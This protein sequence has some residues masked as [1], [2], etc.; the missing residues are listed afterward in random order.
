M[1]FI[2][3]K[4]NDTCYGDST[5]H[6][7]SNDSAHRGRYDSSVRNNRLSSAHWGLSL[8]IRGTVE[9]GEE[10]VVVGVYRIAVRGTK[11]LP[12]LNLNPTHRKHT[13]SMAVPS[14]PTTI[15]PLRLH[16]SG[17][18]TTVTASP[19]VRLVTVNC[20]NVNI[21]KTLVDA[22][23]I[24]PVAGPEGVNVVPLTAML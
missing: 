12:I 20:G 24:V 17:V 6:G 23:L 9:V 10:P 13:Y 18:R 15:R 11:N 22:A 5:N 7:T 4:C 3:C 8:Q 1:H 16:K 2:P 14:V 21:S 19:G